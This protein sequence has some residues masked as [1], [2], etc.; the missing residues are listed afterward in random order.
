[1]NCECFIE[2]SFKKNELDHRII[3]VLSR[4]GDLSLLCQIVADDMALNRNTSLSPAL[5]F[6]FK[7]LPRRLSSS[8]RGFWGRA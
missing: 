8:K 4:I 7:L 5:Y 6:L 1:V 3:A 2:T